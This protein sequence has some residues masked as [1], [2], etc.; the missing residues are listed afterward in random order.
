MI[1]LD[2]ARVSERDVWST[3][4]DECIW[5]YRHVEYAHRVTNDAG[6]GERGMGCIADSE[7]FCPTIVDRGHGQATCERTTMHVERQWGRG[8]VYKDQI[9]WRNRIGCGHIR[10]TR[11]QNG[12]LITVIR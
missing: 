10:R 3:G 6:I 2:D 9:A 5:V 4:I 7:E 11:G 8:C 1:G 12:D